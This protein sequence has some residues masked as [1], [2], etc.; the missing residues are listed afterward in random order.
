MAEHD[1]H[2][3][4]LCTAMHITVFPSYRAEKVQA[5]RLAAV[6]VAGGL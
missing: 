2:V 3:S 6:I 4:G 5:G 1:V